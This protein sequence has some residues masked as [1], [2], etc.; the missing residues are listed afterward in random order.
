M[1]LG[2]VRFMCLFRRLCSCRTPLAGHRPRQAL[3]KESLEGFLEAAFG[4]EPTYCMKQIGPEA[5]DCALNMSFGARRAF[6]RLCA[7]LN[8]NKDSASKFL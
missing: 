4:A 6:D 3:A 2:A 8:D 7:H 1:W 5:A